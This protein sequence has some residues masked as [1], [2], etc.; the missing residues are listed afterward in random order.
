MDK[1]IPQ[2]VFL[3]QMCPIC[4]D[5]HFYALKIEKAIWMGMDV[6][7]VRPL[8]FTRL[9]T[10]P[11]TN[12][13]FQVSTF[14]IQPSDIEYTK[15]LTLGIVHTST[16]LDKIQFETTYYDENKLVDYLDSWGVPKSNL[17]IPPGGIEFGGLNIVGIFRE[18]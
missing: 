9:F 3:I 17:I 15:I 2:D 16:P 4:S 11:K 1:K 5:S 6:A 18:D 14:L 13:D 10:C 12:D 8:K 7:P